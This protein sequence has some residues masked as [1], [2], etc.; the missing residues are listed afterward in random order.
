M[1]DCQIILSDSITYAAQQFGI[2]LYDSLFKSAER[3]ANQANF[4][5]D[6][7]SIRFNSKY[8][9]ALF[10][11]YSQN[12]V[13]F[14]RSRARASDAPSRHGARLPPR[15]EGTNFAAPSEGHRNLLSGARENARSGEQGAQ[16]KRT[17]WAN[18]SI[19]APANSESF[20]SAT[21]NMRPRLIPRAP[22][23]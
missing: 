22:P 2:A 12:F 19:I 20:P 18:Y 10:C 13:P 14:R 16:L 23:F 4:I 6:K 21:R 17:K 1:V 8:Q 15:P 11:N 5:I 3:L 7:N 9:F